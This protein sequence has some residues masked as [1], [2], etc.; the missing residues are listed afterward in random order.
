MAGDTVSYVN[1]YSQSLDA[2]D[3]ELNRNYLNL[4]SVLDD[5]E[6][7]AVRNAQRKWI[8]FRDAELKAIGLLSRR[9][10]TIWSIRAA[11][12]AK[13]LTKDQAELLQGLL[14]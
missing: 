3:T 11:A 7:A 5:V 13:S 2:W 12:L 1:C 4:M 14:P 10:G 6:Q 9:P 8:E